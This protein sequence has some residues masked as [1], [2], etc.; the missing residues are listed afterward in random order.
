MTEV[1]NQLQGTAPRKP[2]PLAGTIM[3]GAQIIVQVLAD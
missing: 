3:S 2:H 1:A